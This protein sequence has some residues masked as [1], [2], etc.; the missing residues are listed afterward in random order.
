MGVIAFSSESDCVH[1]ILYSAVILLNHDVPQS[2]IILFDGFRSSF[3][4]VDFAFLI[5]ISR[6]FSQQIFIK[7]FHNWMCLDAAILQ[8]V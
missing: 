3:L 5:I 8:I 1:S 4:R 2:I 6:F 7:S